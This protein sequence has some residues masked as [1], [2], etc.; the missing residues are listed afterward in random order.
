MQSERR[1]ERPL[2]FS[3]VLAELR[4]FRYVFPRTAGD[5]SGDRAVFFL[6]ERDGIKGIHLAILVLSLFEIPAVHVML[7]AWRP[8]LAWGVLLPSLVSGLYFYGLFNA[9]TARPTVITPR[10]LQIRLGL[11]FTLTTPLSNIA[12]VKRSSPGIEPL[13]AT[14]IRTSKSSRPTLV[15]QFHQPVH[16]V[17]AFGRTQAGDAVALSTTDDARF[18]T[19]LSAAGVNVDAS[20]QAGRTAFRQAD[21]AGPQT[22]PQEIR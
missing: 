15:I 14:I 22:L 10:E 9:L 21:L 20:V 16:G 7:H 17:R 6:A 3:S 19:E 18:F 12:H 1:A 8:S 4:A 13:P 5:S 11:E 2:P